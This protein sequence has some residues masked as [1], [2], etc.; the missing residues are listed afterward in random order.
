V[1]QEKAHLAFLAHGFNHQTLST[2]LLCSIHAKNFTRPY[3][4][5]GVQEL[6]KKPMEVPPEA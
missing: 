2:R 5:E 3:E 1:L 6:L 4:I